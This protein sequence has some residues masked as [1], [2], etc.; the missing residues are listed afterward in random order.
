VPILVEKASKA[1]STKGNPITLTMDE[2]REVLTS[3]L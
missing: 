2:L 3:A 1:S